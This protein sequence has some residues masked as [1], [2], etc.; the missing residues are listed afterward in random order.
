MQ[1]GLDR[2]ADVV[3]VD[4]DVQEPAVPHDR[5]T[6]TDGLQA[7]LEVGGELLVGVQQVLHLEPEL[8]RATL[9]TGD[10]AGATL[11]ERTWQVPAG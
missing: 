6:V 2:C 3:R 10:R 1:T 9:T 8:R 11:D 5:Y 4:V 7:R